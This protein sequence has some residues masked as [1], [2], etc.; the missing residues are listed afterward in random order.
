MIAKFILNILELLRC[1]AEGKNTQM[2]S[3]WSFLCLDKKIIETRREI[4]H[5][6]KVRVTVYLL[7]KKEVALMGT[8]V[9][10]SDNEVNIPL[11]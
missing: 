7:L 1:Q 6:L 10:D 5:N 11:N 4:M 9:T 3:L 8:W 2:E